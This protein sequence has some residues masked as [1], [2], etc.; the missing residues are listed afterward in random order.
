MGM[1]LCVV[2]VGTNDEP[3]HHFLEPS[4]LVL[5]QANSMRLTTGKTKIHLALSLL[6]WITRLCP[7]LPASSW[8]LGIKLMFR[9][10]RSKHF[11]KL[12]VFSLA[13]DCELPWG[14][15]GRTSRTAITSYQ[16]VSHWGTSLPLLVFLHLCPLVGCCTRL[17]CAADCGCSSEVKLPSLQV[18]SSCP[19]VFASL[20]SSLGLRSVMSFGQ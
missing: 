10:L 18:S 7:L 2:P 16:G 13:W 3:G 19:A 4:T 5:S 9:N 15:Q 1:G 6:C 11:I 17:C 14:R 20:S 8:V 12:P